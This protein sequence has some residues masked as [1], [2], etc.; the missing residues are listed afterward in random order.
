MHS[1]H[2]VD[3]LIILVAAMACVPLFERLRLGPV[4]G[5][6]VAGA[7]IGPS[8]L[9]LVGD[10]DSIRAL[11]ELGVVFLLFTI[12]LELTVDRLRLVPRR[13]YALGLAQVVVTAAVIAIVPYLAGYGRATQV[14]IGGALALSSTAIVIPVLS[15][16]GNLNTSLGRMAVAVL[17]LQDLAVGP[18]L[19]LIET[20]GAQQTAPG[21]AAIATE[22][23][24]AVAKATIAIV[25]IMAA[26]RLLLRPLFRLVAGTKSPELFVG[27]VLLVALGTSWGTEQAG[28][29]MAF[30]GLLAGLLL[31][32]TEFR[33][34]VAADVEPF[35]GLLLGL[36]FM[37][38]GMVADL[39]LV[40]DRAGTVVGLAVA[41]MV[42][43]ATVLALLAL[44]FG[45]PAARAWR[46][47]ALL[48]QGG[49]FAFIS[50][51]AAALAGIVPWPLAQL[52]IV[53]V[54][55]TMALT[56]LL[57]EA[58][59]LLTVALERRGLVSAAGLIGET[60]DVDNHVVIVGFGEIGRI[61]ARMLRAYGVPY[62]VLDQV[63]KNV[64]AG[65]SAG[66]PVYFGDATRADV[67]HGARIERAVAIVVATD[68]PGIAAGLA[69]LRRH[70]FPDVP[71]LARGVGEQEIVEMRRAGLTPVGQEA[72][73]TGLKLSGA[74]LDLWREAEA[75]R[76][77]E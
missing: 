25:V 28:L 19:V 2:L 63:T 6:L 40:V 55:L 52:L 15:R 56:P 7:V 20:L 69:A 61:V 37:T 46:L 68:T 31:A 59:R 30:G 66:E 9:S 71:I 10:V 29:S 48:S 1:S 53:V 33:H 14:I 8:G 35:R 72:T 11:A 24:L 39:G 70:A 74:V 65:R 16:L 42:V 12:G 21:G 17:I 43:K 23:G 22:L 18:I 60:L 4:L 62:V 5:Y 75:A 13:V 58:G 51:A 49:E 36:F 47:G 32:E 27:M 67:L 73:D 26:G 41:L 57:A 77:A 38:V 64:Q 54:A 44:A 76:T 45:V 34:Q 50:F 3:V